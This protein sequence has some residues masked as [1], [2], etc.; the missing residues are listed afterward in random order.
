MAWE[1]L[2]EQTGAILARH[3]EEFMDL[4]TAF[5]YLPRKAGR[6][7]A[8]LSGPGGPAVS[9]A[10]ACEEFGLE[11]AELREE[12]RRELKK[13]IPHAG[14]SANNPVDLGLA[15]IFQVDLYW[16]AAQIVGRDPGVDALIL[17]GRGA[18]PELDY[19][20]A[21]GII[22][23]QGKIEKPFMAISLGGMYLEDKSK[24]VL[25]EAGIPIFP[26]AE[27]ALWAYSHLAR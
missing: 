7:L 20:Y 15:S 24:E 14:T 26:S 22:E 23:A 11:V 1:A 17:Q 21:T 4:L 27:R 3:L 2:G 13:V 25:L 8:I 18:T 19:Q 5:Y 10:D 12:T 6:R 16:R 9:A